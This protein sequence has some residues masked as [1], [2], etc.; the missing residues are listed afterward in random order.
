MSDSEKLFNPESIENIKK[1][2]QAWQTRTSES[3]EDKQDDCRI[4]DK[5]RGQGSNGRT[6]D[7][8]D[9]Y[10]QIIPCHC[11]NAQQQDKKNQVAMIPGVNQYHVIN[12]GGHINQLPKADKEHHIFTCRIDISIGHQFKNAVDIGPEHKQEEAP[13]NCLV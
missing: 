2:K 12:A 7:P 9:R 8:K 4:D 11:N 13:Y 6:G 5:V 10:Q 1:N 3:P